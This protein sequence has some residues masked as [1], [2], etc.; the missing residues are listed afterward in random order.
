MVHY[1]DH[2][3][4]YIVNTNNPVSSDYHVESDDDSLEE[5]Y[6]MEEDE[7]LLSTSNDETSSNDDSNQSECVLSEMMNNDSDSIS[8]NDKEIDIDE[9][10]NFVTSAYNDY[11]FESDIFLMN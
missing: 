4:S 7:G 11:D 8:Y 9:F 2:D 1:V 5:L 3:G 6:Y 10:D